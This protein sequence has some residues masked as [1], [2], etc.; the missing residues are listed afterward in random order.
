MFWYLIS[1]LSLS[2]RRSRRRCRDAAVHWKECILHLHAEKHL[3]QHT[4]VL[5]TECIRL[6]SLT[7]VAPGSGLRQLSYLFIPSGVSGAKCDDSALKIFREPP[8]LTSWLLDVDVGYELS[9][10]IGVCAMRRGQKKK[11][12]L[13]F[14]HFSMRAA[15]L[16]EI[17]WPSP[18]CFSMT[19]R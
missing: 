14:S 4:G 2:R 1:V 3:T 11:N 6:L 13:V 7:E 17:E 19:P 10:K 9:S 18:A 12:T 8:L 5:S 16:C 15:S